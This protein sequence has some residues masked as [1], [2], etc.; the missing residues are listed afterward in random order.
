MLLLQR[1][2]QNKCQEASK[3]KK[4]SCRLCRVGRFHADPEHVKWWKSWHV[5]FDCAGIL[6]LL[7]QQ[8]VP[9]SERKSTI[10]WPRNAYKT[11]VYKVGSI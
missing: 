1:Q 9:S 5:C 6:G 10:M 11:N 4:G 7:V 2:D 8:L 3:M